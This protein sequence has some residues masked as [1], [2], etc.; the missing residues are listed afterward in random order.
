MGS[1]AKGYNRLDR[2]LR[3]VKHFMLS[4]KTSRSH[5]RTLPDWA[6]VQRGEDAGETLLHLWRDYAASAA[7]PYALSAFRKE[8]RKWQSAAPAE[9]ASEFVAS[10]KFW[11]GKA[12]PRPDILVLGNGAA[13]RIRGG[14]LEAYSLG[15]ATRFASGPHHRKPKALGWPSL[16]CSRA[17]LHR[18]PHYNPRNR[19]AWRLDHLRGTPPYSRRRIGPRAMCCPSGA[20][21]PRNHP[22]KIPSLFCHRPHVPNPFPR[23]QI[24]IGTGQDPPSNP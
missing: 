14:H 15:V 13:L 12:H 11:K 24:Q 5:R 19:M 23:L 9:S 21:R 8:F 18:P 4:P 20:D 2:S 7:Q 16:P 17:F 1:N 6:A 10:E 22:P 3:L